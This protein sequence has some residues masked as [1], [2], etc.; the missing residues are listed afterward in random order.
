ME[1][2]HNLDIVGVIEGT[3]KCSSFLNGWGYLGHY[4]AAFRHLRDAPINFIEI[5]IGSGASLRTWKSFFTRARIVGVD[6]QPH[7]ARFADDRVSI[8][9]G[10]QD[11]PG[12]LARICT[13]YPPTVIIDDGSH[14]ADHI[15]YTFERM[16]PSL[17]PG[18]FYV[19]ED[20][21]FHFGAEA[22]KWRGVEDVSAPGYFLRIAEACMAR[23]VQGT[24]DWGT[25]HYSF[26]HVDTVQFI[27]SAAII[28]KKAGHQD[29]GAALDFA[30]QYMR[31]RPPDA[32]A[33]E[34]LAQY[35]ARHAGPP[36]R[37][38]A[39][40]RRAIEIGETPAL[41]RTLADHLA[42]QDRLAEA[43]AFAERAAQRSGR[44][45]DWAYAATLQTRHGDHAAAARGLARA[46]AIEPG[47]RWFP[48]QLSEAHERN[49]NWREALAA[50]QLALKAA[51][52]TE[53]EERIRNRVDALRARV[54]E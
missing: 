14:R 38:E 9:I 37:A 7:C 46:L 4:E 15:V 16:F 42:S 34:R 50:A 31:G 32:G 33:H 51:A 44:A 6:I 35:I 26:L 49:G 29:I 43:V 8:E 41:L 52:G 30:E 27:S 10:S 40:L 22:E 53:F 28:R 12:F 18:G 11:D 21:A 13:Q 47:H 20:L 36:A 25:A 45:H 39:A 54:G 5:G 23:S 2:Q 19:V 3:D 24:P 48:L 17:L 1:L